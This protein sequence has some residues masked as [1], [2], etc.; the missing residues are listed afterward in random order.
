MH[1]RFVNAVKA[2]AADGA[3]PLIE[4]ESRQD[5]HAIVAT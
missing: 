2:F 5:K 4:F 3:A 1:D